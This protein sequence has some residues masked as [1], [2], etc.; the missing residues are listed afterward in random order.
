MAVQ[1]AFEVP[2]DHVEIRVQ[3]IG[4]LDI[5]YKPVGIELNTGFGRN[6]QRLDRLRPLA[7]EIAER[8]LE[9][10]VLDPDWR[11]DGSYVWLRICD[12]YYVPIGNPDE[13][14]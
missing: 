7:L 9:Q 14:R 12:G 2:A 8:I 13:A 3:D 10:L 1:K 11:P 6:R 4:P 5:N